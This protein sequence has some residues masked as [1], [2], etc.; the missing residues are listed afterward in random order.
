M[1][2]ELIPNGDDTFRDPTQQADS[3]ESYF[4]VSE[5]AVEERIRD[6]K[7]G[8]GSDSGGTFLMEFRRYN[9]Y[10]W[11]E[12]TPSISPTKHH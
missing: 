7:H 6:I 11:R 2:D 12:S 9:K 3:W 1:P 5:L 10:R 4:W 8:G